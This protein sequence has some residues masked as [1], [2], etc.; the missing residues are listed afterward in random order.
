MPADIP[1]SRIK[2][3]NE[4]KF[5][6]VAGFEPATS[7]FLHLPLKGRALPTELHDI[8]YHY[9]A[10]RI[11]YA[12]MFNNVAYQAATDGRA[13]QLIPLILV[14]VVRS[15]TAGLLVTSATGTNSVPSSQPTSLQ[16]VSAGIHRP[17]C[18]SWFV[19]NMSKNVFLSRCGKERIR[20]SNLTCTTSL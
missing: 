5:V 11:S 4:K 1:H 10:Q 3:R 18:Q 20:T 15:S 14:S 13:F 8:P 19:T 2:M 17:R 16:V 12:I 6:A 9:H 7:C